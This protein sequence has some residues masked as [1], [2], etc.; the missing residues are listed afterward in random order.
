MFMLLY[1]LDMLPGTVSPLNVICTICV[2]GSCGVK[3]AT[4]RCAPS[5]R[6]EDV[7]RPPLTKISKFPEPAC[8]P[9]TTN[10]LN[11]H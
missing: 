6:T 11:D 7:T 10:I 1:N 8:D 5:A 3:L 4:N 2:P 9:S